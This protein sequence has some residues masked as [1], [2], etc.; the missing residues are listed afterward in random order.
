MIY[1]YNVKDI[2]A[3]DRNKPYWSKHYGFII[4]EID[5]PIISYNIATRY[6]Q[7]TNE[8][9]VFLV[10]YETNEKNAILAKKHFNGKY[11]FYL[12]NYLP[13]KNEDYNVE[14]EYVE[15]RKNPTCH[16]YKVSIV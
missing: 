4:A 15:S 7:D 14:L 10:L 1:D 6:N 3:F 11:R 16:I 8:T 9:D 2:K 5:L 13:V 12:N